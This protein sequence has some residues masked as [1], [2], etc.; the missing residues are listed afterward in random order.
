RRA[1][2]ALHLRAVRFD[3]P[4]LRRVVLADLRHRVA[5]VVVADGLRGLAEQ[6]LGL[7]V[8][9][10]APAREGRGVVVEELLLLEPRVDRV[11]DDRGRAALL[12][13]GV[14]FGP[15]RGAVDIHGGTV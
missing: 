8:E 11:A 3:E 12:R 1:A 7:A 14:A 6:R 2:R 13:A 4:V 5:P 9:L 10:F 15:L